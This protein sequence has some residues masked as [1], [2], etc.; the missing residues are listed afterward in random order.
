[1]VDDA[2]EVELPRNI[3][4]HHIKHIINAILDCAYLL[5]QLVAKENI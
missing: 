5:K 2:I 3:E 4:S 1:M